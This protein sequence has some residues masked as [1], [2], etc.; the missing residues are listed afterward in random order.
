MKGYTKEQLVDRLINNLRVHIKENE[1]SIKRMKRNL[2]E[3]DFTD[4]EVRKNI[5]YK[6]LSED[7]FLL[8]YYTQQ[9]DNLLKI[10]K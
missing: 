8:D 1:Q 7:E 3:M 9:L 10:L 2:E 5:I 4:N 6:N